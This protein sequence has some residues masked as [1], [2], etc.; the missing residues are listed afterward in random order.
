MKERERIVAVLK[1]L[2]GSITARVN[3]LEEQS[4][5]DKEILINE[6][7][8]FLMN[9]LHPEIASILLQELIEAT[10]K[11]QEVMEKVRKLEVMETLEEITNNMKNQRG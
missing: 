8:N 1:F 3:D 5:E 2:V 10:S 11:G 9:A 7:F 4:I 6:I